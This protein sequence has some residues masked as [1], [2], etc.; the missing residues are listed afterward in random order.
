MLKGKLFHNF[1]AATAK[2]LD[3]YDLRLELTRFKIGPDEEPL[4]NRHC[5]ELHVQPIISRCD[6]YFILLL[7]GYPLA[8]YTFP[9]AEWGYHGDL[10]TLVYGSKT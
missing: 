4:Q 9:Y 8:Q 7:T 1:G 2:D 6:M 5:F 10:L 3:P